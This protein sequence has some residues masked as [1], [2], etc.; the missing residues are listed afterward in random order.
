MFV[1]RSE[2][3]ALIATASKVCLRVQ[4]W[5]SEVGSAGGGLSLIFK[6]SDVLK[7]QMAKTGTADVQLTRGRG[8]LGE[9]LV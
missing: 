2:D 4:A 9:G 1:Y 5:R 8:R 6:V 3:I 7:I